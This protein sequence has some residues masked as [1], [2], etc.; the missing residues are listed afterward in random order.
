MRLIVV[1][2][3]AFALC[4]AGYSAFSADLDDADLDAR[5][6]KV[7][8]GDFTVKLVDE[9]GKPVTGPVKYELKRLAF[10]LGTCINEKMFEEGPP[11]PEAVKYREILAKYFN[12]AVHEQDFKWKSVEMVPGRYDDSSAMRQWKWCNE[13]GI[14]MRGHCIFWGTERFVQPWLKV[15][16]KDD[17]EIAMKDRVRRVM[18]DYKGKITDFDVNNE[19]MRGDYYAKVLGINSGAAYFKWCK[20]IN[21]D[22]VLYTNEYN[23]V[24][25][26]QVD[27]YVTHLK[28]LIADGAPVGGIG[29]QGQFHSGVPSNAKVWAVFDKLAQFNLPIT[30]TEFGLFTTDERAQAD[31][32]SRF[33]RLCFAH[34]SIK[35]IYMWGFWEGQI[36]TPESALWRNNWGPK[37][38]GKEYIKLVEGLMTKGECV[39]DIDGKINIRGYYGD[40]VVEYNNRRCSVNFQAGKKTANCILK[41]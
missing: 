16:K 32:L 29:D 11:S 27:K 23:I 15:L 28:Q 26:N 9:N 34:P 2:G 14:S 31:D 3:V 39:A 38:A 25:A 7:R 10:D 13:H 6:E 4:M 41:P 20:E 8:K 36:Y 19:M 18:T 35:G 40:Y 12:S 30:I 5:I 21:P 17:L 22:A 24:A 37:R 33:F 1:C